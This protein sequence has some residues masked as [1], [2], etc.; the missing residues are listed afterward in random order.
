MGRST[1]GVRGARRGIN[2]FLVLKCFAAFGVV[3]LLVFIKVFWTFADN[4]YTGA[5]HGE[6]GGGEGGIRAGWLDG[7]LR[8]GGHGKQAYEM[9][10]ADAR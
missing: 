4:Y 3:Q 7:G 2:P 1:A 10:S 9:L 8:R 6:G 5:S